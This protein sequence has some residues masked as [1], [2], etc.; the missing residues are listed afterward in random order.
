MVTMKAG[1]CAIVILVMLALVG[2]GTAHGRGMDD[3]RWS[4]TLTI[5]TTVHMR[6]AEAVQPAVG[7]PTNGPVV[8]DQPNAPAWTNDG[9][10][11]EN[12]PH[13]TTDEAA[14]GNTPHGTTEKPA[15]GNA[16]PGNT[17]QPAPENPPPGNTGKTAAGATGV[18]VDELAPAEGGP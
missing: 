9:A 14:P 17:G 5:N 3:G 11:P 4:R 10:S 18:T 1:L 12:T 13:G 15:P 7:S 16:P 8:S 6:A 2:L